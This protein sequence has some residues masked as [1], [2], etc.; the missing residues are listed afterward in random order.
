MRLRRPNVSV[1][2]FGNPSRSFALAFFLTVIL[3][4]ASVAASANTGKASVVR[5][6]SRVSAASGSYF[7]YLVIILMENRNL[8]DIL[9][10]CG[11][12]ATYLSNLANA[13]G[14]AM[15]DRYCHVNPSLPNYLC[16]TGG[17]D[18]GCSGH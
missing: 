16:L 14:L 13:Y 10:S 4:V 11:G 1:R 9:T 3:S 18:F 7:D 17:T 15:D 2:P 6:T 8:C 12:S 5:V